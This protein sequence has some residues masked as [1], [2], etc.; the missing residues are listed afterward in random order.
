MFISFSKYFS[1][2]KYRANNTCSTSPPAVTRLTVYRWLQ[3]GLWAVKHQFYQTS[4]YSFWFGWCFLPPELNLTS[5]DPYNIPRRSL[6]ADIDWRTR[7]EL[8]IFWRYFFD[9]FESFQNYPSQ[10][11]NTC[12]YLNKHSRSSTSPP[13][14][15]LVDGLPLASNV[16]IWVF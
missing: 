7:S 15:Y 3:V 13:S 4:E 16:I 8:V 6:V 9:F 12:N 10:A 14:G 5:N 11:Q 1:I 2:L